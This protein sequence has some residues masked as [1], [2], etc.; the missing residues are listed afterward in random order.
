ILVNRLLREYSV[1]VNVGKPQVVYRE[2]ITT[3]VEAK[4]TFNREIAGD[5]HYAQVELH[6]EPRG[7]GK[8]NL[9]RE[10]VRDGSIPKSFIPSV[11][12]GVLESLESGVIAGYPMVDVEVAV[13]GG[14]LK[15]QAAS[16]L[17]FKVAASTAVQEGCR[18]AQPQLLEPIMAVEII[19]PE[20]FTGE[21]I[22]DLNIR[23]GKIEGVHTKRTVKIIHATVAL[24][25]M[26]G[27]ST[28]LRSA[29]QGRAT[30]TMQFSH[31]DNLVEPKELLF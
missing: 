15:E 16:E 10:L 9:F 3:A 14:I 5:L 13:I 24:S 7:R 18:K 17:A 22:N 30:F 21:V 20:E 19:V 11:E 12:E 27:Y 26:F 25:Q 1:Q 29:S 4:S 2:T 31:Y 23:K 28:A 8:G 6:L